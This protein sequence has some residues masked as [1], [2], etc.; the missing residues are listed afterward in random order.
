MRIQS[1]TSAPLEPVTAVEILRALECDRPSCKCHASTKKGSGL[2][3]CPAHDDDDPSLSVQ[4][5]DGKGKCK[6]HAGCDYQVVWAAVLEAVGPRKKASSNG[7]GHHPARTVKATRQWEVH[8]VDG[9]LL[10]LHQRI[11]Y[12][13]SDKAYPWLHPDGRSSLNGEIKST[14]KLYGLEL[15]AGDPD[16]LIVLVEGEKT[17]DAL[18][19]VLGDG[20]YVLATVCG[21]SSTPD[22]TVLEHLRGR[23]VLLWPDADASG[24]GQKHMQRIAAI[25]VTLDCRVKVV[26]WADAPERGDAADFIELH[27]ERQDVFELFRTA[28]QWVPPAP[29]GTSSIAEDALPAGVAQAG[30]ARLYDLSAYQPENEGTGTQF[31]IDGWLQRGKVHLTVAIEKLGKSTQAARRADSVARGGIDLDHEHVRFV[32]LDEYQSSERLGVIQDACDDWR[33]VLLILDPMDE[34][35][36]LDEEGIKNPSAA[37]AAFDFIRTLGRSGVTVDALYHYNNAGKI[38]NS[39]KFRSK[40]DHIYE[41]KGS[42]ASDVTISYR[43]RSRGIPRKRRLTGNGEDG[44]RVENLKVGGERPEGRP[45]KSQRQVVDCLSLAEWELSIQEVADCSGKSY[46]ATVVALKRCV[47]AGTVRQVRPGYYGVTKPGHE[48]STPS[49]VTNSVTSSSSEPSI[50]SRNYIKEDSPSFVTKCSRH[51]VLLQ[52]DGTCPKCAQV[53]KLEEASGP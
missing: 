12:S 48:T 19:P 13:N 16:K 46:H 41:V 50:K 7:N 49:F 26:A 20:A 15:L 14:D 18:R 53:T 30:R 35:L 36:G 45:P 38:A 37:G 31:L 39:Y 27:P 23:R 34:C 17:A 28:E 2:T 1:P 24:A 8:G 29:E 42:D 6:C 47:A 33:P 5:K 9:A 43:G 25:L 10:A 40:P 32:F 51:W 4:S 11:D 21:A 3:H 52:A 44:Y 22:R